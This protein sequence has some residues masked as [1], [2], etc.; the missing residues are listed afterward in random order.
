MLHGKSPT[1]GAG[2]DAIFAEPSCLDADQRHSK[3]VF[4]REEQALTKKVFRSSDIAT[5]PCNTR[6][7]GPKNQWGSGFVIDICEG[8]CYQAKKK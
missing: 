3:V 2:S 8:R 1:Q 4:R 6:S 7:A 5:R